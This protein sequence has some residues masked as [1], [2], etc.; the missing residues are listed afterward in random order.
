MIKKLIIIK[1]QSNGN[2]AVGNESMYS[3]KLLKSNLR[4]YNDFHI[5]VRGNTTLKRRKRSNSSSI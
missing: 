2:Y 4:Y 3:E 5:L 1:D